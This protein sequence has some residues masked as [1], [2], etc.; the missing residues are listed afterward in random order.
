[1]FVGLLD[2]SSI[3]RGEAWRGRVYTI[4][5]SILCYRSCGGQVGDLHVPPGGL[6]VPERFLFNVSMYNVM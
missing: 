6:S 2:K 4:H 1:M 5:K 3:P